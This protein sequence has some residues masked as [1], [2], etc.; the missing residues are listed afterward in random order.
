MATVRLKLKKEGDTLRLLDD[1][2]LSRGRKTKWTFGGNEGMSRSHSPSIKSV[3]SSTVEDDTP[4]VD[5]GDDSEK[6]QE[7]PAEDRMPGE[8]A[9]VD[10]LLGKYT[11]VEIP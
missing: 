8:V 5:M 6:I 3:D 11:M 4:T 2:S 7:I 1:K 9:T 10:G